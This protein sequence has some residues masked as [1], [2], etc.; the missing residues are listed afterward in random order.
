M[1]LAIGAQSSKASR[2]SLSVT[3]IDARSFPRLRISFR[4][5]D[6][7]GRYVAG[8]TDREVFARLGGRELAVSTIRM[9]SARED[10]PYVQLVI[11][12]SGSMRAVLD[13][14]QASA[15]ELTRRL[16]PSVPMGVVLARDTVVYALAPTGNA[17]SIRAA[18][19][20]RADAPRTAIWDAILTAATARLRETPGRRI[21]IAITDGRDNASL[22][23]I[24]SLARALGAVDVP[25]FTLAFGPKADTITLALLAR[26]TKAA[27]IVASPGAIAEA[28][29]HIGSAIA[30]EHLM[31]VDLPSSVAGG[32]DTLR[33][34][35][36]QPFGQSPP[37]EWAGPILLDV[38]RASTS[39]SAS[40]VL[41][42]PLLL[43]IAAGALSGAALF[44]RPQNRRLGI[45]TLFSATWMIGGFFVA[46]A[47]RLAGF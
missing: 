47:A 43:W 27:T 15:L 42:F 3:Q 46:T 21:V 37:V 24:D 34:G 22:I 45:A 2:A 13:A 10:R 31:E 12:V 14:L 17:D 8:L 7:S 20:K 19:P 6:D 11:D 30:A 1:P 35:I 33:V 9:T 44:A 18:L 5:T 28:L 4:A 41:R 23:G 39:S 36:R 29:A 38:A 32:W 16:G 40:P 26:V 25:V